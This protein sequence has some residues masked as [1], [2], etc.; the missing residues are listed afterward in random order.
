MKM[1][2][3]S[4][5]KWPNFGSNFST[6]PKKPTIIAYVH[7]VSSQGTSKSSATLQTS[8]GQ[9]DAIIS[10]TNKRKLLAEKEETR[11]PIKLS[12]YSRTSDGNKIVIN[13]MAIISTPRPE[14]YDFQ[15]IEFPSAPYLQVEEINTFFEE[16]KEISVKGKISNMGPIQRPKGM[17]LCSALLTDDSNTITIDIWENYIQQL[18]NGHVYS[19]S[20]V[21]MRSWQGDFK[22]STI[23]DKTIIKELKDCP[24]LEDLTVDDHHLTTEDGKETMSVREILSIGKVEKF[25]KCNRCSKKILQSK[26]L[27]AHCDNCGQYTRVSQCIKDI[28]VK[29]DITPDGEETLQLTGFKE[30]LQ[31]VL[32]EIQDS[33]LNEI[34]EKL[35]ELKNITITFDKSKVITE[36]SA[37]TTHATLV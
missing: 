8:E 17:N 3:G 16:Y 18:Q 21:R 7:H 22:I 2:E 27:Y 35:M 14:E 10:S 29:F 6:S 9:E 20:P 31:T 11:T 37:N 12:K 23:K 32:P 15:Y 36:I 30:P 1:A 33:E 24:E 4:P 26:S 13:E 5:S 28:C 19:L 25:L 34:A